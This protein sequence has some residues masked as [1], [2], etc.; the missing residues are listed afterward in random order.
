MPNFEALIEYNFNNRVENNKLK[1]SLYYSKTKPDKLNDE[2]T[3]K[4]FLIKN[5]FNK[6]A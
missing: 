6:T 5:M 3:N 4:Q 1:Y 2:A